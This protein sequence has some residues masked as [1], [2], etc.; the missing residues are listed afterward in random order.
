MNKRRLVSG[1]ASMSGEVPPASSPVVIPA[2]RRLRKKSVD[3]SPSKKNV[4]LK[5]GSLVTRAGIGADCKNLLD[6]ILELQHRL[7]DCHIS[8]EDA[9]Q[10]ANQIHT[11][12]M[13]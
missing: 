12:H 6:G 11:L 13:S 3:N 4:Q 7:V 10:F 2:R 1:E 9:N 5:G 8:Q